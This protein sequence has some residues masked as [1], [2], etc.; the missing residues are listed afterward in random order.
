MKMIMKINNDN[1]SNV[2]RNINNIMIIIVIM[3]ILM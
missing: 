3:K 1:E 2:W